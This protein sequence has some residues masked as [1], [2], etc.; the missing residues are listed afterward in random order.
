MKYLYQNEKSSQTFCWNF[1][2]NFTKPKTYCIIYVYGRIFFL[3]ETVDNMDSKGRF[4]ITFYDRNLK[5]N[6]LSRLKNEK[7]IKG[8]LHFHFTTEDRYYF[9]YYLQ[10]SPDPPPPTLSVTMKS[11]C[12]LFGSS[13]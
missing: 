9:Y 11:N 12:T 13:S 8:H 7:Y 10:K 1:V 2:L 5:R 4:H 6:K 3:K